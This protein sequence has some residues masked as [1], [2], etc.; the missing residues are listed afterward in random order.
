MIVEAFQTRTYLLRYIFHYLNY[1]LD[2]GDI[3]IVVTHVNTEYSNNKL[4]LCRG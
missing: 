3:E 1:L 2:P 4:K